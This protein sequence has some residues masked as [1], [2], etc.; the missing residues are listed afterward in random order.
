MRPAQGRGHLRTTLGR[1]PRAQLSPSEYL[2]P[3]AAPWPLLDNRALG[4]NGVDAKKSKSADGRWPSR[5]AIAV[6]SY[7]VN[8][9]GVSDNSGHKRCWAGD[10]I[11][12]RGLK[13]ADEFAA[14]LRVFI[15]SHYTRLSMDCGHQSELTRNMRP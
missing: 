15:A 4:T 9:S 5:R 7:S 8:S 3:T 12:R 2:E 10:R 6:P 11:S 1:G 13:A 14:G